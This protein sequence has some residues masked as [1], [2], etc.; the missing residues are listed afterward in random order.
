M[1]LTF[2]SVVVKYSS[3]YVCVCV[4]LVTS[5]QRSVSRGSPRWQWGQQLT[6]STPF[7]SSPSFI[8]LGRS[9]S[10]SGNDT[11]RDEWATPKWGRGSRRYFTRSP[12]EVRVEASLSTCSRDKTFTAL[13]HL[14]DTYGNENLYFARLHNLQPVEMQQDSECMTGQW[15]PILERTQCQKDRQNWYLFYYTKAYI[16]YHAAGEQNKTC[17]FTWGM[18]SSSMEK[19]FRQYQQSSRAA[20][21]IVWHKS[22]HFNKTKH[23][24]YKLTRVCF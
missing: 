21:I 23:T 9:L 15:N 22:C 5:C 7:S 4:C 18:L 8:S 11:D 6:E 17:H 20:P 16:W 12:L 19:D 1:I 13:R 3:M 14:V 2:S 24:Q 10:H